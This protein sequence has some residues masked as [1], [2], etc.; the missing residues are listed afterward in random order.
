MTRATRG[1][2]ESGAIA[3]IVAVWVNP[4]AQNASAV[5]RNNR[6]AT[7]TALRQGGQSMAD[8]DVPATVARW[9]SGQPAHN[10]YFDPR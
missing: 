3:V 2:G 6:E 10:P 5:Y 8:A 1:R 9:R 7:L 4:L